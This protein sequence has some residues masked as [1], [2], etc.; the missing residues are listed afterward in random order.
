MMEQ[1][2][3]TP[4]LQVV[5]DLV[6]EG[7]RLADVGTDHAHLPV[8]LLLNGRIAAAIASDIRPGPLERAARTVEA[9]RLQ[10]RVSLRLCPGLEGVAPHEADT[11][12]ICGMGGDMMIG[13]L[14]AAPWTRDGV[15]LIL[16]PQSGQPRLRRWLTAHGYEI[17]LEC[18]AK[19]AHRWYPVLLVRGGRSTV[20]SAPEALAGPERAWRQEP[21]RLPYL[22]FLRE[23]CR[24]QLDAVLRS[25]K[26][27]DVAR[28]A[29]LAECVTALEQWI[30]AREEGAAT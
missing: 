10:E 16:Q 17:Q 21:L 29:E 6:P 23:Q 1:L 27:A 19:E 7:A 14:E 9:Y 26:A 4:R 11:V 15:T 28:R 2:Q 22:A 25:E 20:L 30:Q 5:A 18:L 3:L 12:T 13:I 24:R 8:W